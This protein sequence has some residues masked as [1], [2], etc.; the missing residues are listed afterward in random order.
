MNREGWE[1]QVDSMVSLG[2]VGTDE[3]IRTV[4]AYLAKHFARDSK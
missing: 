1:A 4:I 3:E 2:A